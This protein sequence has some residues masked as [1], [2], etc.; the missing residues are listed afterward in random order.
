MNNTKSGRMEGFVLLLIRSAPYP[1]FRLIRERIYGYCRLWRRPGPNTTDMHA[2]AQACNSN[3]LG[4]IQYLTP[5]KAVVNVHRLIQARA[6]REAEDSHRLPR[7]GVLGIS[8]IHYYVVH[9]CLHNTFR[10]LSGSFESLTG[11]FGPCRTCY[12]AQSRCDRRDRCQRNG[13]TLCRD[14]WADRFCM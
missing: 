14:L 6:V 3:K 4:V 9:D 10:V 8:R 7:L 11:I 2:A 12:P 13:T 1:S 5:R